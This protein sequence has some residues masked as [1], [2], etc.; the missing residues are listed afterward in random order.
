VAGDW[1]GDGRASIGVARGSSSQ[2][3]WQLKN[4]NADGSPDLMFYWGGGA[5]RV[6]DGDWNA[7]GASRV[8]VRS[9]VIP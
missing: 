6:M 9:F 5:D 1:D 2:L 3:L 8:G 7:S 4:A